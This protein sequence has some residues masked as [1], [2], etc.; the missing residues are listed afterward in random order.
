MDEEV[1]EEEDQ[2]ASLFLEY[3]P[4][5]IHRCPIPKSDPQPVYSLSK[6]PSTST[7]VLSPNPIFSLPIP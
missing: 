4:Q 3:N 2:V 7:V 1:E 5:R 6:L